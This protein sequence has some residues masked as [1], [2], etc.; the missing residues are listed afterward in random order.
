MGLLRSHFASLS[1]SCPNIT[2]RA[3]QYLKY[4]PIRTF[5]HYLEVTNTDQYGVFTYMENDFWSVYM[6]ESQAPIN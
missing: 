5:V 1:R 3:P 4:S 2:D 6:L